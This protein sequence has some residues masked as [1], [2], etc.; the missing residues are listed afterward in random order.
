[1]GFTKEIDELM[2]AA[3]LVVSKPGGLTTSE[4]LACEAILV[5]VNPI[6]GQESRNS[7]YP[8]E[9]DA[10]IKANN[11]GTLGYKVNA[12]CWGTRAGWSSCAPTFAGSPSRERRLTWWR[13]RWSS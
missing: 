11:I 2:Q 4:S 10:A 8:L 6:P 13:N 7:D 5:I 3:D 9:S 1:M 12:R